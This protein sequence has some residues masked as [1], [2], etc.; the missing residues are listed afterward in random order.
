MLQASSPHTVRSQV[1]RTLLINALAPYLIYVLL[2]GHTS[3]VTALICSAIPPL[4][5]S[6]WSLLRRR[7]LDVMA[8]LVLG[9]ILLGLVLMLIGGNAR[10][11]L[12][13]ESLVTGIV[14]LVFLVSLIQQ[15]VI[16]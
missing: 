4:L 2:K 8:V 13:R 1:I 10:L 5:E 6:L 7:R 15:R 11:L 14:G 16:I 12:V 3:A 9:G